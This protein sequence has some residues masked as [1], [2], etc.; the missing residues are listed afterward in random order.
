M[1]KTLQEIIKIYSTKSH[2]DFLSSLL[3]IKEQ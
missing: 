1:N 3:K 2:I